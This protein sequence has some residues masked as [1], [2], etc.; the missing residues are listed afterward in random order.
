MSGKR[1]DYKVG[2]GKPPRHTQFRKGQ[3]GN[4]KGRSKGV[5]NFRTDMLEELSAKVTVNEGRKPK[6]VTKQRAFVKRITN[7]AIQ[8]NPRSETNLLNALDRANLID[9]DDVNAKPLNDGEQSALERWLARRLGDNEA[10]EGGSDQ[11]D[12]KPSKGDDEAGKDLD[13]ATAP[14]G[15]KLPIMPPSAAAADPS[16]PKR[17]G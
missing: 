3:S 2:Y 11:G 16:R 1:D 5:V 4:P 13:P 14:I 6:Q 10:I 17:R 8:G 15:A 12:R 9:N 7:S